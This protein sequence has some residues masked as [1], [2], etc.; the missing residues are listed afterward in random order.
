MVRPAAVEGLG[1]RSIEAILSIDNA[2]ANTCDATDLSGL[3]Q[4]CRPLEILPDTTR[5]YHEI[6]RLSGIKAKQL[7]QLFSSSS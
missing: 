3:C 1:Y 6:H 7:Q 2:L 5:Q 4:A